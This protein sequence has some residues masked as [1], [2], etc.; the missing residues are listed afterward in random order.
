MKKGIG[1]HAHLTS[2]NQKKNPCLTP[3]L[4]QTAQKVVSTLEVGLLLSI[5]K[6]DP[7]PDSDSVSSEVNQ[8]V[9]LFDINQKYCSKRVQTLSPCA[10]GCYGSVPH[11]DIYPAHYYEEERD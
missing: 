10:A 2:H 1:L 3:R 6:L 8:P 4:T 5:L 7:L 9:L 11:T